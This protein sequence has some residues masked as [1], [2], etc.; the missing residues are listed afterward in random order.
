MRSWGLTKCTCLSF[1]L[2]ACA[3]TVPLA[4]PN[5]ERAWLAFLEDGKT[6]KEE[7][8]LRFGLP[9]SQFEG[10]RILTYRLM[11]SEHEG[12][13]PVSREIDADDP[14]LSQWAR[15]EF[16]LV[17]IFDQH[18]VLQRHSLIRVR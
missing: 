1:L 13:L 4:D 16:S 12:L 7:V 17:L 3:A 14:R 18:H 8:L 9:S 10:E 2:A 5:V 15:A 11:L 6:R